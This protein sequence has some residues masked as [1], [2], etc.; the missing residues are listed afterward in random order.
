MFF[1]LFFLFCD[2]IERCR[3]L[4]LVLNLLRT[5]QVEMKKKVCQE[6]GPT[7]WKGLGRM[8]SEG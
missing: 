8:K 6:V 3:L 4:S 5:G 1:F 2:E 7:G